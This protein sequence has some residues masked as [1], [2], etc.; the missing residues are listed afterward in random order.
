M[1]HGHYRKM[2]KQHQRWRR[3]RGDKAETELAHAAKRARQRFGITLTDALH[4]EW[5]RQITAGET[6]CLGAES[7]ARIHHA[8]LHEGREV[9]VVYDR[10]RSTICTVLPVSALT[11]PPPK[12]EE[13]DRD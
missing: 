3:R 10:T 4:A 12:A 8:V 9:P 6:R 5:V 2:R 1:R 11:A 7:I 13:D